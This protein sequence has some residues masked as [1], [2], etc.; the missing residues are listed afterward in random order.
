MLVKSLKI[1]LLLLLNNCLLTFA[2]IRLDT[3]IIA[4]VGDIML[5]TNYPSEKYL[6][7]GNNCYNSLIDV[8]EYLKGDIVFANLEGVFAGEDG[9]PKKCNDTSKCYVFRMPVEYVDCIKNAGFNVL[10]VANNHVNDFSLEGRLNTQ[11]VLD[12]AGIKYAG[13]LSKPYEIFEID[14]VKYGFTAFAPNKGTN[15]LLNLNK[16][17]EIVAFLDSV[18]DIVIVSMHAGAEGKE[19]QFVTRKNEEFYGQNRGNVYQFAHNVINAGADIVLGHGPHVTRAVEIYNNRFI[20]YSLGNFSTY[21]RFNIT[22]PNGIAPILK[23]Y[24]NY[25]GEFIKA[26]IIPVC[27][28]GE[29][30]TKFDEKGRV[31]SKIRDLTKHDFPEQ[32]LIIDSLGW[33]YY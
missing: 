5:G 32:K 25:N 18:A 10:S 2:Q 29:G 11:K 30:I 3:V 27:Q 19:H 14:S 9:V 28:V 12:S 1:F 7:P 6:P 4:A 24:C 20:A 17:I 21:A 15:D 13:F 26:Q 22:G 23:V 16:A 8:K 31:I 33:I